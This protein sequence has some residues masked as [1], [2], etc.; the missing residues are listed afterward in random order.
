M[1]AGT[2]KPDTKEKKLGVAA[3]K[4]NEDFLQNRAAIDSARKSLN[5][6]SAIAAWGNVFVDGKKR[7]KKDETK[8]AFDDGPR[9]VKSKATYS[10]HGWD[11]SGLE[12][13]ELSKTKDGVY[14]TK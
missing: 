4:A 10:K 9:G 5:P 3:R 12:W 2:K 6:I 7:K 13:R 1:P 8:K 14:K 11:R